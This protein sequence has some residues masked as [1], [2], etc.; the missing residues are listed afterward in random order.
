MFDGIQINPVAFTIPIGDGFPIHWYG[1]IV[2][3]GIAI[4]AFWAGREVKRRGGDTDDFYNG[5]IIVIVSGFV[6]ARLCPWQYN[7]QPERQSN[8]PAFQPSSR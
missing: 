5:L 8:L 2:T 3:L 7:R 1:I 4:G 6:F